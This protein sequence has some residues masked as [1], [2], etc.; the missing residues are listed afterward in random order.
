M[1]VVGKHIA[2][3]CASAGQEYITYDIATDLSEKRIE[4]NNCQAV[5]V[6]VA[7]PQAPDGSAD[8][9]LASGTGGKYW[10]IDLFVPARFIKIE[11]SAAQTSGA[12]TFN[13]E[14]M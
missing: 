4:I 5:F 3:D 10:V 6:C 2:Q 14:I 13:C 9:N 1:G 7:T 11:A 8:L 12:I